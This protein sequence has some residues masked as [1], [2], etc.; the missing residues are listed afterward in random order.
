MS[1]STALP[2]TA[3]R[4]PLDVKS[5]F[6]EQAKA[7]GTTQT[8]ILIRC[9]KAQMNSSTDVADLPKYISGGSIKGHKIT[10][11]NLEVMQILKSLGVGTACGIAGYHISGFVREQME[12]DEDKG[13][14]MAIGLLFGLLGTI[15]TTMYLNNKK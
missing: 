12:L 7:L 9:A 6:T 3:F 2:S 1:K 10:T 8:D 14:Q 4:L 15:G 5:Y 13:T 11:P